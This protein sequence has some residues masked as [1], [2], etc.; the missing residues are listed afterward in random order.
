M[1]TDIQLTKY[2]NFIQQG[3]KLPYGIKL[4]KIGDRL[5]FAKYVLGFWKQISESEKQR[6][7]EIIYGS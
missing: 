1:N 7:L 4:L 2:E 5:I 6:C 3:K